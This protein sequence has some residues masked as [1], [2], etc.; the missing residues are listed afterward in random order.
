MSKGDV[1]GG[2]LFVF[3]QPVVQICWKTTS[4]YASELSFF[5]WWFLC[6]FLAVSWDQNYQ[7]H[8]SIFDFFMPRSFCRCFRALIL[9]LRAASWVFPVNI[10]KT[11]WRCFYPHFLHNSWFTSCTTIKMCN[12][13]TNSKVD[14]E[15]TT[16][17]GFQTVWPENVIQRLVLVLRVS[18][19]TP[20]QQCTIWKP[21][22]NRLQ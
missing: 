17:L 14:F 2:I 9:I 18:S 11:A 22:K 12:Y 13:I 10:W 8:K 21:C 15:I 3:W 16:T 19:L 5:F 1:Q 6:M 4:V 20:R 7:Q